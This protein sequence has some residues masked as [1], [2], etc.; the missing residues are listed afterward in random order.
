[1]AAKTTS[2]G[3]VGNA[4]F[5]V[6]L[7][8][9]PKTSGPTGEAQQVWLEREVDKFMVRKAAAKELESRLE[10][11]DAMLQTRERLLLQ[12]SLL[13]AKGVRASADMQ[14]ALGSVHDHLSVV[15]AQLRSKQDVL[16]LSSDNPRGAQ[17][18]VAQLAKEIGELQQ[19]QVAAQRR[20]VRRA[21]RAH[22]GIHALGG[23]G[24][25]ARPAGGA[26]AAGVASSRRA[27]D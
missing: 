23:A 2:H 27:V 3:G 7:R 11:R 25:E 13:E 16:R 9:H 12:R 15:Q 1:M 14:A 4:G 18:A 21:R 6:D 5:Q 10:E 24:G 17:H 22:R 26:P 19:R 8:D 20:I